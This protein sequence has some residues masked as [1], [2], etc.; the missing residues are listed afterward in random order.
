MFLVALNK[1]R[2]LLY[3]SYIGHVTPEELLRGCEDIKAMAADLKP[4]FRLLADFGRLESMDL[5]CRTELG[6]LMEL[7]DQSGVGL[8]VRVIPDTTKDIGV[9]I[10]A[11]FHYRNRPKS[12]TCRN[13]VEAAKKL[14]L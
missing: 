13:L 2:Q 10:L 3:L 5:A 1:P 11:L 12:V 6:R 8:L 14:S 7:A 4:G 9:D